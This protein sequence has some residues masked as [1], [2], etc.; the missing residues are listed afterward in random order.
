MLFRVLKKDLK[1]KRTMNLIIF[2]FICIAAMFLAGSVSVMLVVFRGVDYYMDKSNVPDYMVLG[3]AAA[4]DEKGDVISDWLSN[5]NLVDDYTAEKSIVTGSD[6]MTIRKGEEEISYKQSGASEILVQPRK[7]GRIFEEDGNLIELDSGEIAIPLI[8]KNP[9]ALEIGDTIVVRLGA[10][11]KEFRIS[12]FT[13]DAIFGTSYMGFKRFLISDADY[14]QLVKQEGNTFNTWYMIRTDQMESFQKNLKAQNFSTIFSF[15][16][17]TAELC[18]MTEMLIAGILLIVSV[19]LILIS[20]FVLRFTIIFTIQEDYKD[21]GVMKAI[22]VKNPGIKSIYLI[23]YLGLAVTGSVLGLIASFPFAVLLISQVGENLLME[24]T[25]QNPLLNIGCGILVVLLVVCFCYASMKKLDQYSAIE[26]IRSGSTGERFHGNSMI[27]LR[28]HGKL[29]TAIFIALNDILISFRK[30]AVMMITFCIGMMLIIIP[31]NAM[32]TLKDD[33]MVTLFGYNQS[34]FYISRILDTNIICDDGKEKALEIINR[35]KK[36]MEQAGIPAKLYAEV[37]TT[38]SMHGEDKED[39]YT[40]VTMQNLNG[41]RYDYNYYEGSN[42]VLENEIALSEVCTREM[43]VGIGDT[44]YVIID[45]EEKEFILTGIFQSMSNQGSLARLNN[46]INIDYKSLTGVGYLQGD[47]IDN[48]LDKNTARKLLAELYP[49]NE[50]KNVKQYISVALG[51]I[52]D[53]IDSFKN[54]VVM[55]V[56]CIDGLIT[57]LMMKSFVTKEAAE[58]AMLKS[59]GFRNKA[60]RCIHILRIG[61]IQIVSILL[62]ILFSVVLDDYTVGYVFKFM[63]AKHLTLTIR[64]QEIYMLYPVLLFLVPMLVAWVSSHMV[65]KISIRE[66]NSEE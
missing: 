17:A 20:F 55:L 18:Y 28:K 1:R 49:D 22:G 24:D 66:I 6:S 11:E 3:S 45:G 62:G 65:G 57:V 2:L 51:S 36:Q 53:Q 47:F 8:D 32:N 41:D 44:V 50:V 30:Y 54:L 48:H 33:G 63:G 23:K 60:L 26:A 29:P 27:K 31:V 35:M 7:Y 9:N 56:L 46:I 5:S 42:P 14:N 43:K 21:I 15:S 37:F 38:L 12:C 52:V 39:V 10:A 40:T 19:C 59:I 58:I 34:D 61:I 13:K 16:R 64:P 25:G 4:E